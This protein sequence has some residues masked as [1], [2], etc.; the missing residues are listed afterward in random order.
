MTTTRAVALLGVLAAAGVTVRASGHFFPGDAPAGAGSARLKAISSRVHSKGVSLV[1]EATSPLAYVA[2][3]PDPLTV[4]LDFR[5]VV[6]DAVAN[7]VAPQ[8][9]SPI[10]GAVIE[11]VDAGDPNAPTSRL[12]IALN[13]P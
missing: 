11:P 8:P 12:R 4:V 6:T 7:S 13:H 3:R 10:A 1:V 9:K 2:T 5:N